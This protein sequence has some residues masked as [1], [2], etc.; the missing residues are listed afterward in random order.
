MARPDTITCEYCSKPAPNSRSGAYR[1]YHIGCGKTLRAAR[2]KVTRKA[3]RK[4]DA[5]LRER[6]AQDRKDRREEIKKDPKA[7]EHE[8]E[9]ARL[10]QARQRAKR[11]L[12]DEMKAELTKAR[13]ELAKASDAMTGAALK[14]NDEFVDLKRR[15]E[16][17]EAQLGQEGSGDDQGVPEQ[18][19][20]VGPTGNDRRGGSVFD[21]IR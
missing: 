12:Y 5:A 17:L 3:L 20:G 9:M 4:S 6:E 18:Q 2:E 7:L 19:D 11:A 10:R 8:R 13:I 15:I 16:T 14:V 21:R 1:K